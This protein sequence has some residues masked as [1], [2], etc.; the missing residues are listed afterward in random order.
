MLSDSKSIIMIVVLSVFSVGIIL[1]C[2]V[3]KTK[4]QEMDFDYAKIKEKR[5]ERER[6]LKLVRTIAEH[7]V[8]PERANGNIYRINL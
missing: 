8:H 4:N 1:Y 2:L 6:S 7:G 5:A 3:F